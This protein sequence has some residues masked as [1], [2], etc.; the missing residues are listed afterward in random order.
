MDKK[1]L[2]SVVETLT[3]NT[4]LELV[5]RTADIAA[6]KTARVAVKSGMHRVVSEP[7]TGRGKGGSKLVKV[8]NLETG[9][10][11]DVGTPNSLDVTSVSV[12]GQVY[13]ARGE[14]EDAKVF[15][16][17]AERA[18]ELKALLAPLVG[19]TGKRIDIEATDPAFNGRFE[20]VSAKLNPGRYGQIS[21]VLKD[22]KGSTRELWTY[23]HASLIEAISYDG[24]E[25]VAETT[26]PEA[27][28]EVAAPV[29]EKPAK[30]SR[31]G[32]TAEVVA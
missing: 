30:R 25:Q 8:M 29:E 14:H 28:P 10:Q 20:V 32:K 17:N 19:T 13:A 23:R 21:M 2:R 26:E 31:K 11:Y 7:R 12:G 6:G 5:F 9:A 24:I 22:D 1:I 18:G 27:Q 16:K 15:T 3:V 4:E